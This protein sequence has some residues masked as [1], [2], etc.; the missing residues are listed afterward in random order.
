MKLNRIAAALCTLGLAGVAH[1][2]GGIS[3]D[4]VKVGVLTDLSLSLIHI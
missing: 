4:V 3:D 1:A 2:Q